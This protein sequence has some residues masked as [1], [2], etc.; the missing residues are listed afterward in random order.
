DR[1][2]ERAVATPRRWRWRAPGR[3]AQSS[4]RREIPVPPVAG[5]GLRPRRLVETAAQGDAQGVRVIRPALGIL[6]QAPQVLGANLA[7]VPTLELDT[8]VFRGR[9]DLRDTAREKVIRSRRFEAPAAQPF[10][11]LERMNRNAGVMMRLTPLREPVSA[12]DV[13][14][15][16]TLRFYLQ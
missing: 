15:A 11:F 4:A 16:G 9:L 10:V 6:G 1:W 3:S 7:L 2:R 8:D 13:H 12:G 14:G 5:F